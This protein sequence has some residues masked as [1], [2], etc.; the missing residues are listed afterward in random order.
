[1][2]SPKKKGREHTKSGISR[3]D[4]VWKKGG[5]WSALARTGD[6]NRGYGKEKRS[7]QRDKSVRGRTNVWEDKKASGSRCMVDAAGGG[8]EACE[9]VKE[10]RGWCQ[11]RC[12]ESN[13]QP[14]WG[15][16]AGDGTVQNLEKKVV[17]GWA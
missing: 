15:G 4:S 8:G 3:K 16:S 7:V 9:R 2:I 13:K 5:G 12:K 14:R 11:S 6:R 17:S 10:G 1:V